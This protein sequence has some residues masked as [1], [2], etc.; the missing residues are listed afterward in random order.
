MTKTIQSSKT[1]QTPFN[2]ALKYISYKNRSLKEV[3]DYL[4]KNNYSDEQIK[5]TIEKLIE[6]KFVDDEK[7]SE[8]FIRNRQLKGRSKKMISYE[9]RQKGINKETLEQSLSDAQNDFKTAKEY[10]EK[11][12]HQMKNLEPEKRTQMIINRLKSRG[13]NWDTIKK[14]LNYIETIS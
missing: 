6:Y 10:I 12:L 11:R 9:L 14:V 8:I 13:Y 5:E 3:H 1:I 7:F 4:V 2:K